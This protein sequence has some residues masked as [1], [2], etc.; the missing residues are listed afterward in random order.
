MDA[1]MA[2]KI[3]MDSIVLFFVYPRSTRIFQS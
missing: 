3:I 1:I 2:N